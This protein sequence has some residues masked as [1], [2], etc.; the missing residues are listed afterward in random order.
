M[1]EKHIQELVF[2]L[3]EKDVGIRESRI[4]ITLYTYRLSDMLVLSPRGAR[5]IGFVRGSRR[6]GFNQK[7]GDIDASIVCLPLSTA[8]PASNPPM[9]SC[10]MWPNHYS[11]LLLIFENV[12][13]ANRL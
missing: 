7:H 3:Y 4:C 12:A 1:L 9:R 5:G 13:P 10:K 11:F 6:H 8:T 2:E